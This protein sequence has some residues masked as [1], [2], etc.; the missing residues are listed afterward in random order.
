[1]KH[2]TFGK[3]RK[4]PWLKNRLNLAFIPN[5]IESRVMFTPDFL[6]IFR[7]RYHALT[8]GGLS[9]LSTLR[10]IGIL[11]YKY[12]HRY[13]LHIDINPKVLIHCKLLSF[14]NNIWNFSLVQK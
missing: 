2:D 5:I 14:L 12:L 13:Y 4:I 10:D 1:M 8:C 9:L 3:N 7:Y 6:S 11:T